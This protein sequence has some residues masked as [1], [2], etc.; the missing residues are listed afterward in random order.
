M[1][2]LNARE[3][4][5]KSIELMQQAGSHMTISSVAREAGISNASIHNRYPELAERIR[6]LSGREIQLDANVQ[7]DKR[8]GRIKEEKTKQVAL[9]EDLER[10]KGL[11]RKTNSV[12]AALQLENELL[13]AQL[14]EMCLLN[15]KY[16]LELNK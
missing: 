13:R 10:L 15:R 12:N 8:R 2:K 5:E 4:I 9:R 7:L 3:K 14:E 16:I 6:E 11:L 1:R